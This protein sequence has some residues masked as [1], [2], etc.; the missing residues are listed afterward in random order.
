MEKLPFNIPRS[1]VSYVEQFEQNPQRI[2]EKLHQHVKRRG[3][4]AVGHFLLA[5]FYHRRDM[6]NEALNH[7]I[8][9][10]IY[11]PGSPLM[12]HLHYFL[13]H[14]DYFR[15]WVPLDTS[16]MAPQHSYSLPQDRP[17][18]NLDELIEQLSKIE[19]QRIKPPEDSADEPPEEDLSAPPGEVDELASETLANIHERQGKLQMAIKTYRRL[20]KLR[21][22]NGERYD[23]KIRE[24][25]RKEEA[26]S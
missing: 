15:A 10:R 11:A 13:Q 5:W 4:D 6:H 25:T 12:E 18:M 8:K 1:L 16:P 2:T 26:S 3:A 23:K 19:A 21:P 9:A 14:P 7:S 22:E 20:K 17:L 24:L